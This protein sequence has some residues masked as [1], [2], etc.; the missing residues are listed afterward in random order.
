MSFSFETITRLLKWTTIV[1]FFIVVSPVALSW[2]ACHAYHNSMGCADAGFIVA[3][4]YIPG[5][6]MLFFGMIAWL[7]MEMFRRK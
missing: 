1:G 7:V 5:V 4:I 2:L 3:P 6:L